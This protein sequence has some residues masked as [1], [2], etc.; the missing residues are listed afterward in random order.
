MSECIE[1]FSFVFQYGVIKVGLCY[2][3]IFNSVSLAQLQVNKQKVCITHS[4]SAQIFAFRFGCCWD[5]RV[6]K[7][8]VFLGEPFKICTVDFYIPNDLHHIF[9]CECSLSGHHQ[10]LVFERIV[11]KNFL[12][13]IFEISMTMKGAAAV[14]PWVTSKFRMISFHYSISCVHQHFALRLSS[15]HI[16]HTSNTAY[17][18]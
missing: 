9:H 13:L 7:S 3:I 5:E 11:F 10:D 1:E 15:G 6:M 2:L 12:P 17:S 8:V 4:F 18:A 16:G 14:W